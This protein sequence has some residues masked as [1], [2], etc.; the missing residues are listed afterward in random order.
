MKM[1]RARKKI[2]ITSIYRA[3][4]LAMTLISVI[5]LV[6][7]FAGEKQV[8]TDTSRVAHTHEVITTAADFQNQ[9]VDAETGQRGFLLT[10]SLVYLDPYYTGRLGAAENL[11]DLNF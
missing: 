8:S 10:D 5:S 7:F 4:F 3:F 9:L 1:R 2:S 11:T 6:V